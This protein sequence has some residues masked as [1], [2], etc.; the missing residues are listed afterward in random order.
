M[1]NGSRNTSDSSG[2]ASNPR[3]GGGETDERCCEAA[4]FCISCRQ[5]DAVA[6]GTDHTGNNRRDGDVETQQH[7]ANDTVEG[8]GCC[9]GAGGHRP[10]GRA[11]VARTRPQGMVASD[12]AEAS[13]A[14]LD[15]L[16][17]GGNAI[18]AA[19]AVSFALGVTRPYSTGLGGGG[20]LMARFADGSTV[21]LDYRETAPR[22]AQRNMYV[23]ETAAT[24][25]PHE[26]S[27][28]CGG[29]P[30]RVWRP[31]AG[32]CPGT[33]AGWQHCGLTLWYARPFGGHSPCAAARPRGL[34]RRRQLRQGGHQRPRGLR[35]VP[36]VAGILPVRL[37][38]TTSAT[39][40]G[41]RRARSCA[42]H[43]SPQLLATIA[44]EGP[45]D[46][47]YRGTV[48]RQLVYDVQAAGRAARSRGSAGVPRAA[49]QTA[50]EH[51][52]RL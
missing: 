4:M 5:A 23:T 49:A 42:S 20:F 11:R 46:V 36:R 45:R 38:A 52:S 50:L 6:R 19:A 16:R 43:D 30:Q 2:L 35:E 24:L 26:P 44:T 31:G 32:A 41:S 22:R 28:R 39:A 29:A 40:R 7:A 34:H 33:L 8:C 9:G 3:R 13:R 1:S 47:F 48:A 12:S 14:G 51:L 15:V 25:A 17:A 10:G 21:A 27:A 37:R 18:D